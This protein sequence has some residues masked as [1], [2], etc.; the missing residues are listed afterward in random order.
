MFLP[1][2]FFFA[3]FAILAYG[4]TDS[5]QSSSS[6]PGPPTW[7]AGPIDFSGLI[8]GYYSF[9]ANH[10][11]S[12]TN[13]LRNFDVRA[14]QFSLNMAKLEMQHAPDPVGFR[15]DLGLGRAFD[16]FHATEP[17]KDGAAIM[18]H[19]PQAYLTIA[20]K[21]WNGFTFDF[22]KFYTSAGAELTETHLAWNYSRALLYAN[23]PYYHFGARMSKP[24][25]SW[26][27][28]GV[29]IIN[30]W[31]NV[32]DNNSGKT[33]GF[34]TAMTSK[35]VSWFNTYYVGP[36]KTGTNDGARHF[37]DTVLN[38]NPTDQA[39][40]YVNFDYGVDKVKSGQ[41]NDWYGVSFAH[42]YAFTDWF[43]LAPRFE[44]YDDRKGFITGVAQQ[45]KE[46]TFTSE[47]K[48]KEGF[49]MRAEFRRDWSNQPYFDRGN[50]PGSAKS[51]TTLLVGFIAYF[52]PKR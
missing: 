34:T 2:I 23:G 30:G 48:M 36:E 52:G 31:N 46:F 32:E 27:T 9:N 42:R 15:L 50:E 19:I 7:S 1:K 8:D 24:L 6:P 43:A 47:F 45:L 25:T 40:F 18:R 26:F 39:S 29:Q 12:R 20:P 3:A 17:M 13:N 21:S 11:A 5:S 16:L 41:D 38:L 28:A 10:P 37:W 4:Q 51:Q 22:G 35:K 49:L 33:L 14:N 44:V